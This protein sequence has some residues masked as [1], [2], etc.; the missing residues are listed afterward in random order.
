MSVAL[1]PSCACPGVIFNKIGRPLASTNA[2][3]LV[4]SPPLERPMHRGSTASP[5]SVCGPPFYCSPHAGEHGSTMSRSSELDPHKHLQPPQT[6]DPKHLPCATSRTGCSTSSPDHS[7]PG[8]PPKANLFEAA[9]ISRSAPAGH[10]H[11]APH[12]ACSAT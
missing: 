5:A 1:R 11:E 4:V 7:A 8:C 6:G 10:P 2:W 12:A 9:S 3:I